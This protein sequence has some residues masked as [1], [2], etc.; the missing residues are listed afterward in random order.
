VKELVWVGALGWKPKQ[1]YP[2]LRLAT[3][4]RAQTPPL[5]ETMSAL[6][7]ELTRRRLRKAAEA[8]LAKPGKPGEAPR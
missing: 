6:G 5:F 8:I 7:K 2:L 3:T 1:G 4:A